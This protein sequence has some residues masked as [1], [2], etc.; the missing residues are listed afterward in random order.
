MLGTERGR[1]EGRTSNEANHRLCFPDSKRNAALEIP[2]VK[3]H[4]DLIF[5]EKD[6]VW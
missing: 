5:M 2:F 6:L 4:E 1:N 3:H